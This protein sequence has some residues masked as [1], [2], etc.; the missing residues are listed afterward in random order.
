MDKSNPTKIFEVLLHNT[1]RSPAS[2]NFLSILHHCLLLPG[3]K[4]FID[5][6]LV[7]CNAES[8]DSGSV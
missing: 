2:S 4:L 6:V 5:H 3:N 8:V 1:S 7:E